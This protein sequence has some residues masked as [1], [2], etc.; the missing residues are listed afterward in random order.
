MPEETHGHGTEALSSF[1]K[2]LDV[3]HASRV[4]HW[5]LA[6]ALTPRDSAQAVRLVVVQ[7]A[8]RGSPGE[9]PTTE[10]KIVC[11]VL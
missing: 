4:V 3:V 5:M 2:Q 11:K 9:S 8:S 1:K 7:L 10:C 6:Y